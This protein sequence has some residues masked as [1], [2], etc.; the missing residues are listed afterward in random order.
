MFG[1]RSRSEKTRSIGAGTQGLKMQ[2]V[3]MAR[4]SS[5]SL[6]AMLMLAMASLVIGVVASVTYA[7]THRAKSQRCASL[8]P[9]VVAVQAR[10]TLYA[11]AF[12]IGYYT[13]SWEHNRTLLCTRSAVPIN[14]RHG[15]NVSAN[16][17]I[18]QEASERSGL[19]GSACIVTPPCV[20]TV[21][22]ACIVVGYMVAG[23]VIGMVLCT[24]AAVQ[25]DG[26][27]VVTPAQ[28]PLS[29]ELPTVLYLSDDIPQQ[30]R[31]CTICTKDDTVCRRCVRCELWICAACAAADARR[32][33]EMGRAT[34]ACPH[35]SLAV[36]TCVASTV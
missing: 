33:E 2:S 36:P 15:R 27:N 35:C 13:C 8:S 24:A 18:A 9:H 12:D 25:G 23:V 10:C 31:E 22:L 20:M 1:I 4:M 30:Q 29:S 14:T 16:A 34:A 32:Q 7:I 11:H 19:C 17:M 28:Q 5:C 3:A 26:R 21:T 6:C